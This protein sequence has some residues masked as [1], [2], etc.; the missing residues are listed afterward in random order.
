MWPTP[1]ARD[2]RSGEGHRWANKRRS[3]NLNDAVA[4]LEE[5]KI[6]PDWEPSPGGG[7]LNPEF[8]EWLQGFPLGWTDLEGSEEPLS[9]SQPSSPENSS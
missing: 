5:Y 6:E 2:Y 1:Q 7:Q 4:F 9:Q 8:V 3:R